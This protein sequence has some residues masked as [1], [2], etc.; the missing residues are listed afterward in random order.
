MKDVAIIIINYN[1][2]EFT[3]NCISSIIEKTSDLISYQIIVIDNSSLIEDFTV[4]KSFVEKLNNEKIQLIRNRIN[5]GFGSGNMLGVQYANARYYAFINNDTLLKTDCLSGL[6]NYLNR[7]ENIAVCVPQCFNDK[8]QYME[9]FDH[10]DSFGKIFFGR[11]IIELFN[12]KKY[13]NRKKRYKDPIQV[14]AVAGSFMFFRA[15]DFDAIGGFDT[16]LFLYYEEVD[17][18]ERLYNLKKYAVLIPSEEYIHF[19]GGSTKKSLLIKKELLISLFYVLKKHSKYMVYYIFLFIN[20]L[21]YLFKSIFS[22]KYLPILL[23]LLRGCPLSDSL[24]QL[25]QIQKK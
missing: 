13:P 25:Q 10:F 15:K 16:N 6:S 24:K 17:I 23:M 4:V 19:V 20:I 9:T 12:S 7:N 21:K 3:K 11:K 2:N 8:D 18:C 14:Q 22:F 1:S 5:V